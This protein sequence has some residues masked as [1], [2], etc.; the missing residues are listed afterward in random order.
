MERFVLGRDR[1]TKGCGG[2]TPPIFLCP[3]VHDALI[4]KIALFSSQ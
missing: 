4:G 1:F 3:S 2:W